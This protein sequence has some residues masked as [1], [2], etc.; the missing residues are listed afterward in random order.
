MPGRTLLR[1]IRIG[2]LQQGDEGVLVV[3]VI[4]AKRQSRSFAGKDGH[5]RFVAEMT[6]R[7]S[8]QDWIN[9]TL[10]MANEVLAEALDANYHVGDVVEIAQPKVQLK[11]SEPK[12]SPT[13]SSPFQLTFSD[14]PSS[15]MKHPE[16][17]PDLQRLLQVPT[18][19]LAYFCTLADIHTNP[20]IQAGNEVDLLGA[21]RA[22]GPTRKFKTKGRPEAKEREVREI[23]LFD[24]LSSNLILKLWDF[25]WIH[26]ADD[27][28]PTQDIL[29]LADVRVDKDD[30]RQ[31]KVVTATSRTIIAINPNIEEAKHLATYARH[32]NFSL[33][34]QVERSVS[35]I[36]YQTI[37]KVSNIVTLQDLTNT[38][39]ISGESDFPSIVFG[40]I[41]KMDLDGDVGKIVHLRC[42]ECHSIIPV[43]TKLCSNI[44][45]QAFNDHNFVQR[46]TP[47]WNLKMDVSDSTGT[48]ENCRV[49]GDAATR[50]V[51]KIEEFVDLSEA[52]KTS[53]KWRHFIQPVKLWLVI[54]LPNMDRARSSTVILNWNP[55]TL[56]EFAKD[57]PIPPIQ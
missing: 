18:K 9:V 50:L 54:L 8:P 47:K 49:D 1:R 15:I 56:D 41:T 53:L 45:C 46:Q 3:G 11:E 17:R 5:T 2:A 10:W 26:M 31:C 14:P 55:V 35:T 16:R 25:E 7:D 57:T 27:W 23:R 34:A 32:A 39:G 52:D 20:H 4:I 13:V 6:I 38:G 37:R 22:V 19:S 48:L 21:I 29:F 33:G 44:D 28:T 42:S 12:F 36:D 40:Y 43:A 30:F 51:G 24:Q